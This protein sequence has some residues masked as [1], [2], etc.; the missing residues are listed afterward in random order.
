MIAA[1]G[2]SQAAP[3]LDQSFEPTSPNV[4]AGIDPSADKA[5]TFTVGITGQLT[6]VDVYIRRL[7]AGTSDSLVFDIRET[8]SGVPI[9]DDGTTLA[10]ATLAPSSV[11]LTTGFRRGRYQLVRA[12]GAG[13]RRPGDRSARHG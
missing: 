7:D 13:W 9:E 11:P 6:R 12:P 8:V 1:V 10:S 5:Q 2:S 3:G 4:F